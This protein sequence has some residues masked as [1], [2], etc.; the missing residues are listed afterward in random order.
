MFK[1]IVWATDGSPVAG[2]ALPIAKDLAK[3]NGA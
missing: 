2:H 3:N 1:V